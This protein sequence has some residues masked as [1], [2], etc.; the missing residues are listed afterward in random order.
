M[1]IAATIVALLALALAVWT[2]LSHRAWVRTHW[3]PEAARQ[4]SLIVDLD[5][6]WG[7]LDQDVRRNVL[8]HQRLCKTVHA[9]DLRVAKRS[10]APSEAPFPLERPATSWDTDDYDTRLLGEPE[11]FPEL[12]LSHSRS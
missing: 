1:V 2:Q 9:L 8:A 12:V 5:Q 7:A 10:H 11:T 4:A 6:A 3:A